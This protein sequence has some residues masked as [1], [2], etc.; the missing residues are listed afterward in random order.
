MAARIYPFPTPLP[1]FLRKASA[2][3]GRQLRVIFLGGV[4][5]GAAMVG[6]AWLVSAEGDPVPATAPMTEVYDPGCDV[7]PPSCRNR[8]IEEA[9]REALREIDARR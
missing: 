9:M 6:L 8:I 4:V 1:R 3:R 5:A 2:P 7:T